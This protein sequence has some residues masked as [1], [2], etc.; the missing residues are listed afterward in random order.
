[1]IGEYLKYGAI[2]AKVLVLYGKRLKKDD[3]A[4][5]C[6]KGSVTEV[7]GYLKSQPYWHDA[8]KDFDLSDVH[9]GQLEAELKKVALDEYL[10]IAR[11]CTQGDSKVLSYP[12]MMAEL[13]EIT[14]FLQLL[15][16]KNPELYI[17]E[18][19]DYYKQRSKIDFD[20]LSASRSMDD[21]LKAVA[22]SEYYTILKNV[23]PSDERPY[24]SI[25]VV[26]RAYLYSKLL[27]AINNSYSGNVRKSLLKS[28]GMQIDLINIINIMRIKKYFA[29]D[30]EELQS[31]IIPHYYKIN[32]GFLK[33]LA[34]VESEAEELAL[35][36]QTIYGS[37]FKNN[38]FAYF[39]NYLYKALYDFSQKALTAGKPSVFIPIAYLS[40]KEIEL[41]NVINIIECIRYGLDKEQI[42]SF[43][44]M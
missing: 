30:I 3:Y 1:M 44:V 16:A 24:A 2:W 25:E 4:Q 18:L 17:C 8:L 21:F 37:L 40:L 32:L 22:Q 27:R 33:Q 41:K 43:L 20:R 31:F 39:E 42:N 34:A 38:E 29:Y 14:A 13:K 19:S 11:F 15:Y 9:R 26:L 6:Q 5:L 36:D 23:V 35:F 7:A 28:F 10:R 12:I